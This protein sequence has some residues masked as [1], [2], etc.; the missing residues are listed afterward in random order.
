MI[1]GKKFER[2]IAEKFMSSRYCQGGSVEIAWNELKG[3]R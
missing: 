2:K 1:C 3:Q